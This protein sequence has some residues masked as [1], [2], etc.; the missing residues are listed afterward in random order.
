MLQPALI[1]AAAAKPAADPFNDPQN[2]RVLAANAMRALEPRVA[3]EKK[4]R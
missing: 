3:E 1:A 2:C 4:L